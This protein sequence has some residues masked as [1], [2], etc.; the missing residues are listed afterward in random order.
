MLFVAYFIIIFGI[1][2]AR[3]WIFPIS[4]FAFLEDFRCIFDEFYQK[5]C[6]FYHVEKFGCFMWYS[7]ECLGE[8]DKKTRRCKKRQEVKMR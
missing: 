8:Q 3:D 6:Y 2:D 1:V 7:K 4:F 5:S